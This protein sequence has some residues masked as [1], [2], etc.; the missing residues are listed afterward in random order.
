MISLFSRKTKD[1]HK[2]HLEAIANEITNHG[3]I[4]SKRKLILETHQIEFLGLEITKI[5]INL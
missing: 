1:E 2:R 3:I 4:I 5:S